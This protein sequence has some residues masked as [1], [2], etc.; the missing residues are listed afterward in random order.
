MLVSGSAAF[1]EDSGW[2]ISEADGQ[3]SIARGDKAVYGATGTALEV[4]DVVSTSKAA[5][6]VLARGD[7]FVILA[8][9]KK[10]RIARKQEPGALAQVMDFVGGIFSSNSQK[11][12]FD[13]S[14][15]A[16]VVKGLDSSLGKPSSKKPDER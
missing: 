7:E 10:V 2:V 4:G 13:S 14:T 12:R 11:T 16:A 9:N 6:A 3:V 8:P 5:R 15:S 1:A